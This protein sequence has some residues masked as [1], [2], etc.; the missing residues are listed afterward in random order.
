MHWG[1]HAYNKNALKTLSKLATT[2]KSTGK[3]PCFHSSH[4][5]LMIIVTLNY[6]YP[7]VKG[8]KHVLRL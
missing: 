8:G 2:G 3:K 7:L 4:Y 1:S 5:V 6:A